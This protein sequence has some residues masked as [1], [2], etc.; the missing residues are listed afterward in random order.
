M[1]TGR[2]TKPRA[3]ASESIWMPKAFSFSER[4]V[5]E[6][7]TVPSVMSQTPTRIRHIMAQASSPRE[8]QNIPMTENRMPIYVRMTERS[9]NP[10]KNL[11]SMRPPPSAPLPLSDPGIM[12]PTEYPYLKRYK[13][14]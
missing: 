7:A 4:P 5:H 3:S 6:R 8:A 2:A 14:F 9:Q 12:A 11:P 13:S 10:K 1:A